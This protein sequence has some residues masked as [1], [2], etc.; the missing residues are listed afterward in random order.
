[1]KNK[2]FIESSKLVNWLI[3]SSSNPAAVSLTIKGVL[4][5][6]VPFLMQY[7]PIIGI[8]VSPDFANVPDMVYSIVFYG[9]TF[10]ASFMSFVGFVRKL[11]NT[12]FQKLTV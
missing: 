10:L 7:L 4:V 11:W 2:I 6:V 3:V 5:G 1:M 9:L 8:Q 12:I